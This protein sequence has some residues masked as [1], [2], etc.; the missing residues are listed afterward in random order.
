MSLTRLRETPQIPHI[1]PTAPT[2]FSAAELRAGF[3][4]FPTGVVLVGAVVDGTPVGLL[5]S[6]F[7]SVSL[8][9]PLV[10]VAV[11]HTS[12]T[13]PLLGASPRLGICVLAADSQH[14]VGQLSR[15]AAD[16]FKGVPW[17]AG[18]H[19]ELTMRGAA[20][21]FTVRRHDQVHAGDHDV[22]FFEVLQLEHDQLR[23]PLVFHRSGLHRIAG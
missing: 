6:S 20:A 23:Q 15:P 13:W 12:S 17:A 8:E 16:R 7:T 18:P 1:P 10:S 11:A 22:V 19:G 21:V 9:P 5:A 2:G 3:G 14:L 4:A